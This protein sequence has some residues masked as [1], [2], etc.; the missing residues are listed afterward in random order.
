[1]ISA[2]PARADRPVA[3][4][5]LEWLLHRVFLCSAIVATAIWLWTSFC[6]FPDEIWNDMRVA[7]AVAMARG[8]DV[9]PTLTEGTINT[10]TYGPLPLVFIQPAALAN[11]PSTALVV[12]GAINVLIIL[13]PIAMVCALWPGVSRSGAAVGGIVLATVGTAVIWPESPWRCFYADSVAVSLGLLSQV[14]LLHARA[15]SW[16][17]AAAFLAMAPL[18][19]KQTS[20]GIGV[21]Q[22]LWLAL[23]AGRNAALAHFGRCFVAGL[24][25]GALGLVSFGWPGLSF[26]LL[27]LP[28]RFGW[29]SVPWSKV[30]ALAVPLVVQTL[31]PAAL[32]LARPAWFLR[33]D[34]PL[35]LPA[36]T[37]LCSVPLGLAAFLKPGGGLNSFQAFQLWLPATLAVLLAD[38]RTGP[39]ARRAVLVAAL[40]CVA[41]LYRLQ[42]AAFLALTPKTVSIDQ[43]VALA[44]AQPG[45]IWFPLN[46]LI[47]L[48]T[49]NRYYCDEDGIY[50]RV[51]SGLP[52]TFGRVM[53]DL[54][55]QWSGIALRYQRDAS[56]GIA[57]HMIPK[58]ARRAEFGIWKLSVWGPLA[59]PP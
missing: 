52:P 33:R 49:E 32:M 17:W 2:A 53:P 37:W 26:V 19:C 31:L 46:P 21:A 8:I 24:S 34:A 27:E 48:Y 22:V 16:R 43:G 58:D 29:S 36:L 7:A 9:Y 14:V 25:L 51:V 11:H 50:V 55:P 39:V 38:D 18:A 13:L 28:A 45:R 20:L 44:Q 1:M 10:W 59:P 42:T 4:Q 57:E 15:R 23:T 35:L 30:Q 40:A 41:G 47:T 56:W 5:R 6:R 3:G 54:P 12:A